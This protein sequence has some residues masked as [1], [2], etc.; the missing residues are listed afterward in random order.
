MNVSIYLNNQE[1]IDLGTK[2]NCKY[3][4]IAKILKIS[5]TGQS[6]S[7]YFRDFFNESKEVEIDETAIINEFLKTHE[8]G[9]ITMIRAELIN[10]PIFTPD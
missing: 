5:L 4:E 7:R 6:K 3:D 2:L 9:V 10:K 8:L 1:L